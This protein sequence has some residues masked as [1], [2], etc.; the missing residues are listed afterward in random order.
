MIQSLKISTVRELETLS[1]M[2]CHSLAD[3]GVH[4]EFGAIAD[5]KSIMGLFHLDY[6][7]PVQV[8]CENEHEL[9]RVCRPL[10]H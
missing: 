1:D 3:I 2:A 7:Q 6:S 10:M 8:V 4:D 5:A 9:R